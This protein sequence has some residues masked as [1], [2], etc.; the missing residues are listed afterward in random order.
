MESELRDIKPLLEIPDSSYYLFLE[1]VGFAIL[2]VLLIIYFL[3]KK[4]WKKKKVNMQKVYFEQFKK[5]RL[6]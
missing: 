1:L 4:F 5:S 3:I 6:E 2:V